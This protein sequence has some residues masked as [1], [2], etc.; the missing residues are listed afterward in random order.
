MEKENIEIIKMILTESITRES[1]GTPPY[2]FLCFSTEKVVDRILDSFP[3]LDRYSI[4]VLISTQIEIREGKY[5]DFVW[6][7]TRLARIINKM[8]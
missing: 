1:K 3:K 2:Q 5:T 4:E 6:G 8:I 7:R